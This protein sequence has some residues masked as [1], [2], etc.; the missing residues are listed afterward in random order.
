MPAASQP[1]IQLLDFPS[2]MRP[3]Q[4]RLEESGYL[5]FPP[6]SKEVGLSPN[7]AL[8]PLSMETNLEDLTEGVR[9]LRQ[10]FPEVSIVGVSFGRLRFKKNEAYTAGVQFLYTLPFEEELLLNKVFE[11]SPPLSLE[12]DISPDQLMAVSVIEIESAPFLPFSLYLYLPFNR[13]I[14]LYYQRDQKLDEARVKKFK[15]NAHHTLYIRRSDIKSYKKFWADLIAR[16]ESQKSGL[17]EV[18]ARRKSAE[19]LMGLMGDF[20]QDENLSDDQGQMTLDNLKNVVE[21]LESPQAS[22]ELSRDVAKLAAQRLTHISHAQNVAAYC[23]LFGLALNVGDATTLKLGGLLHDL[24]LSDMA[25]HLVGQDLTRM[26]PE[27]AAQY[28]LHPG[29][30]KLTIEEKKMKLPPGV[31]D[32]ILYHHE[33]PDGSGYPYGK[34]GPEIPPLAKVCSFADE[35]DKLTS[36]RSGYRQLN[37][38]EAVRRIA[39]LDGSPPLPVYEESFHK[40]LVNLLLKPKTKSPPGGDLSQTKTGIVQT[41]NREPSISRTLGV[42]VRNLLSFPQMKKSPLPAESLQNP[43]HAAIWKDFH[44]HFKGR[45]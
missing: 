39:G 41:A 26:S 3:L 32:M 21:A 4:Q 40:P 2:S 29:S 30:G 15:E 11:L 37:P 20:F 31:M 19:R 35:F 38:I 25:A 17:G 13:K 6:Q 1:L 12:E 18:D 24:G 27:D 23:C 14:L 42:T 10:S 44:D 28:K 34:K 16:P 9:K 7:L 45:P 8:A 43:E 36:V 5:F 33:R 22:L